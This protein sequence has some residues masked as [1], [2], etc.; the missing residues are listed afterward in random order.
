MRNTI[1][2]FSLLASLAFGQ[3]HQQDETWAPFNFFIGAWE[4]TSK[5]QSGEARIAR[6]YQLVLN[7]KFLH[8]KNKSVYP[9]QEKNPKGEVHE[10]WGM[11]SYDRSRKRFV[12]RQF[13]VEGF[14]NQYA[15]DSLA[16]NHKAIIFVTE[17]IENIPA[18]WRAKESYTI[19]NDDEFVEVFSLAEPG[20]E[21]EV[22]TESRFKRKK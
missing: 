17:E 12:L 10:D 20:K 2:I 1:L 15:L 16:A 13:H 22:Y 19:L 9:P 3:S 18:G 4:G 8:I 11:I 21:F 14:V 7:G 6:E 5:G